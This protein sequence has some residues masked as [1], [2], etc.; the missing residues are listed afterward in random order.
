[1]AIFQK[2]GAFWIDY[3]FQGKRI[4]ERVGPNK[5]LAKQAIAKRKTEIAEK[6]FFPDR[7]KN[8]IPFQEMAETFWRLY[9]QYKKGASFPYMFKRVVEEFSSRRLDEI[10]VPV[11]MEFLNKIRDSSSI[12]NSNR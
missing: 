6:K 11:A 8:S 9:G 12:A 7:N 10:T 2:H 1:M 4:R 5:T 3:Y